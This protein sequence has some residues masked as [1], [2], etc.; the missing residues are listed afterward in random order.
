[1]IYNSDCAFTVLH[2]GTLRA[3][4]F[5]PMRIFQ[6]GGGREHIHPKMGP[7]S[8]GGHKTKWS[9]YAIKKKCICLKWWAT[10]SPWQLGGDKNPGGRCFHPPRVGVFRWRLGGKWRGELF[11]EFFGKSRS[12]RREDQCC[13]AFLLVKN[14]AKKSPIPLPFTLHLK[15][16]T[17]CTPMETRDSRLGGEGW[18]GRKQLPCLR[19]QDIQRYVLLQNLLCADL[20]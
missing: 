18:E 3:R 7:N 12:M 14:S 2:E 10:P 16:P 8:Q 4:F 9:I 15:T 11:C 20:L 17:L 5:F 13:A 1:M 6:E 19:I